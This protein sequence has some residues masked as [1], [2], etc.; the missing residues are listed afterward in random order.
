M[1]VD[2][3][4]APLRRR[5]TARLIALNSF[6]AGAAIFAAPS[7]LTIEAQA[8]SPGRTYCFYRTCHRVKSID[9]TQ[10][11]VG[12]DMT[13]VASHYDSCKKD[14][15]NPCG[16]T[17]S[18]EPFLPERPDNAA[19]PILPDGTIALVW[20]KTSNQAVIVRINNAGPYWG[21]R[22]LDL[23]RA[24]ARKLGI[25]GVGAVTL[26][27]LRAPTPEEARYSRNRRYEP[28]AGPI[29]AFASI[30]EAHAAVSIMVAEGNPRMVALA[31]PPAAAQRSKDLELASAYSSPVVAGFSMPRGA[32]A[33]ALIA[34]TEIEQRVVTAAAP[35]SVEVRPA[36]ISA[37][38]VDP[39]APKLNTASVVPPRRTRVRAVEVK[40]VAGDPLTA[41]AMAVTDLLSAPKAAKPARAEKR[42]ARK[43]VRAKQ[44]SAAIAAAKP[45]PVQGVRVAALPSEEF[46]AG[47]TTY[48]E[49]RYRKQGTVKAAV[50]SAKKSAYATKSKG[51]AP[52][53]T[54][55]VPQTPAK[56]A[57]LP[58]S[59]KSA[60]LRKASGWQ[61]SA[62]FDLPTA[63]PVLTGPQPRIPADHLRENDERS[64]VP[65]RRVQPSALV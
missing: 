18:G 46:R 30:D 23:S 37:A 50:P 38:S 12:R 43:T 7:M 9:E 25:G 4:K 63:P 11:L 27:V 3:L 24:A 28:V 14:R 51:T 19:S 36:D 33:A 16:L 20:S 32:L 15:F 1:F 61:S 54:T 41:I 8:K 52:A 26:R 40:P 62:V 48:A 10:A 39:V 34:Q 59:K 44:A 42:A 35:P 64:R 5:I 17:S 21:N 47:H 31:V 60:A 45:S 13:L 56:Q 22:K 65:L 57:G 55:G 2:L 49:D 29:G 58:R 53:W 6:A